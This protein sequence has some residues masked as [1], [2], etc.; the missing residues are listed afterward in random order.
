MAMCDYY[1]CDECG[2]K[3][4]YDAAIA[5]YDDAGRYLLSGS[6]VD[7]AA[8]CEDCA[9]THKCIVVPRE[10]ADGNQPATEVSASTVGAQRN[11]NPPLAGSSPLPGSRTLAEYRPQHDDDCEVYQCAICNATMGGGH[12]DSLMGHNK[13]AKLCT[14]GLD[15]LLASSAGSVEEARQAIDAANQYLTNRSEWGTFTAD[16]VIRRL[17]AALQASSPSKSQAFCGREC[18][19]PCHGL[20]ATPQSSPSPSAELHICRQPGYDARLHVCRGCAQA[21]SPSD[22]KD[23]T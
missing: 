6:A 1:L 2:G 21:P 5:E 10:P 19:C 14:C 4:F 15:A 20:N 17:L 16:R 12:I 7:I 11:N 13:I 3:C 18:Y 23:K 8:I 9:K 22:Q